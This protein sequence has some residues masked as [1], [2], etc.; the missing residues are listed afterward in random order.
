MPMDTA[1]KCYEVI[2]LA[3]EMD[4]PLLVTSLPMFEC[5]GRLHAKGLP[6]GAGEVNE[7]CQSK[8]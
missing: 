7:R 6:A 2:K 8:K 5:C 1:I 3:E 4:V